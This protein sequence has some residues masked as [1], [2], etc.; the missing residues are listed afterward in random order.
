MAHSPFSPTEKFLKWV[1]FAAEH[2]DLDELNLPY[3]QI[4]LLSYYC[5]DVIFASLGIAAAM[6]AVVAIVVRCILRRMAGLVVPEKIK[7]P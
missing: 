2:P 4:G 7:T 5:L 6:I 3:H 1:E